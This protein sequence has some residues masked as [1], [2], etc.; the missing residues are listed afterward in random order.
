MCS[1]CRLSRRVLG[2][3]GSGGEDPDDELA[4]HAL[5]LGTGHNEVAALGKNTAHAHC[6]AQ[7]RLL[8]QTLARVYF[9]RPEIAVPFH[10]CSEQG[11]V[12]T[13]DENV[14]LSVFVSGCLR[15]CDLARETDP[16]YEDADVMTAEVALF[17]S[18]LHSQ[19]NEHLV[20]PFTGYVKDHLETANGEIYSTQTVLT[21]FCTRIESRTETS[22]LSHKCLFA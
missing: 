5:L 7:S 9:V 3:V 13:L 15:R 20:L 10:L 12:Q 2:F 16:V 18:R 17:L 6:E 22:S 4:A 14:C 8:R 19:S 11:K 21:D 1:H